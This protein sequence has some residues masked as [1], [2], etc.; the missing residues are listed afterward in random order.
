MLETSEEI[1]TP[2]DCSC[3]KAIENVAADRDTDSRRARRRVSLLTRMRD[4]NS[5]ADE[6]ISR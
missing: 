4:V 2:P 6:I 1:A 3:T 5:D